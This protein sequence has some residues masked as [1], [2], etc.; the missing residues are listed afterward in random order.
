MVSFKPAQ[1]N[2]WS[3]APCSQMQNNYGTYV[4]SWSCTSQRNFA[5]IPPSRSIEYPLHTN[6]FSYTDCTLFPMFTTPIPS[7]H[8]SHCPILP[9][10]ISG[11]NPTYITGCCSDIRR[12]V[13]RESWPK[14]SSHLHK[15]HSFKNNKLNSL[16]ILLLSSKH[17]VPFTEREVF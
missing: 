13:W 16:T 12:S 8:S 4:G 17:F 1:R 6:I 14:R 5:G 7:L 9:N 11:C 10:N 15:T 2:F 3:V